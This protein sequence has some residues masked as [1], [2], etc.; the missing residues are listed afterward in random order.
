MPCAQDDILTAYG[1]QI[2][3]FSVSKGETKPVKAFCLT[4]A[5]I[6]H[7]RDL[8]SN[9]A[10]RRGTAKI[11]ATHITAQL[12]LITVSGLTS[13]VFEVVTPYQPFHPVPDVTAWAFP[14]YH[15]DGSCM[16]LFEIK[17]SFRILY[18]GD[19][20]WNPEIRENNLLMGFTI[21]RLYYDDVFDE[22]TDD[23]PS[24]S[25]S[26][27]DFRKQFTDLQLNNARRINI[28]VSMLGV[29]PLLRQLADELGIQFSLSKSLQ[30]TWRG[31]QLV[32]LLEERVTQKP[33]SR[34]VLGITKLD[35]SDDENEPWIVITCTYFL[36]GKLH[37]EK[38]KAHHHY[39][40]FCTHSNNKENTHLKILISAKEVNP[41]GE[42]LR[43][44]KCQN[45][46]DEQ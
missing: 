35:D 44:L 2:D 18:T 30:N 17:E 40:K 32:Y 15:C 37:V 41:C 23:Y 16:F 33:N 43:R 27:T 28:N 10:E 25:D 13:D 7:M 34:Y 39:I 11:F 22:V 19:F 3:K 20:R 1:V 5:H 31:E 4:H 38:K 24:F 9:F 42:S 12:A 6:D 36:C 45:N 26:Y 46:P 8:K 21:D 29:E 14:A